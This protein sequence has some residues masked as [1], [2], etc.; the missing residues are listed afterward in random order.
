MA[1][2]I[3]FISLCMLVNTFYSSFIRCNSCTFDSHV[4]FLDSICCINCDLIVRWIPV[5]QTQVIIFTIHLKKT[6]SVTFCQW[7]D[8]IDCLITTKYDNMG[9][10]TF[11]PKL[12][13]LYLFQLV[14]TFS[15]IVT[16]SK[17]MFENMPMYH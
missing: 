3:V 11:S 5:R 7:Y 15:L 8:F 4:V 17:K 6:K 14:F 2:E 12:Y 13:G 1:S 9:R 10:R 16:Y